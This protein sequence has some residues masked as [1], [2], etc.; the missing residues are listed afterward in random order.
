MYNEEVHLMRGLCNGAS[1]HC[2]HTS[3]RV[4]VRVNPCL[5]DVDSYLHNYVLLTVVSCVLGQYLFIV[6]KIDIAIGILLASYH[7]STTGL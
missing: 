1:Y 3:P 5:K 4:S 7:L 6:V 2:V